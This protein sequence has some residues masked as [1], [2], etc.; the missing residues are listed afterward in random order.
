MTDDVVALL[1]DDRMPA[2]RLGAL[3]RDARKRRGWKRK[4]AAAPAGIS[5]SQLRDYERGIDPVPADVCARLAEAYGED[6]TAH[7]P[8]R[9]PVRLDDGFLVVDHDAQPIPAPTSQAEVLKAYTALLQRLRTAKPGQP[10]PLRA[11]DLAA[12]S[13]ALGSDANEIEARIMELLGCTKDEAAALRIELFRRKVILPVA[14]LAAGVAMLA[15]T[16]VHTTSNAPAPAPT[17]AAAVAEMPT[18][19]FIAET[20]EAVVYER[21]ETPAPA[22]VEVAPPPVVEEAPAPAPETPTELPDFGEGNEE[23]ADID[24]PGDVAPRPAPAPAPEADPGVGI[25]E[26]ETES[27]IEIGDPAWEG[28]GHP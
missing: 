11:S 19:Q 10:V 8:L 23:I 26:G 27:I 24:D 12:L 18:T 9:M 5:A 21:V 7:V 3:L 16:Q 4:R 13:A 28:E 2:A 14:G 25:P 20:S 15:A 22:P 17:P 1:L 6:L